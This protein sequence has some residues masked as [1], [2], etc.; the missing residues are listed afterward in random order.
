M[1]LYKHKSPNPWNLFLNPSSNAQLR[2]VHCVYIELY[3][4]GAALKPY[5]C[6][7]T[8]DVFGGQISRHGAELSNSESN[9]KQSSAGH[10]TVSA[11]QH[12]SLCKSLIYTLHLLQDKQIWRVSSLTSRQHFFV[13]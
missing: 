13:F 7:L 8:P 2:L 1:L 3:S 6:V 9:K 10:R 11:I 4:N 12:L 5:S